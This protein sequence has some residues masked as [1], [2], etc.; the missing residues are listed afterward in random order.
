MQS[1]TAFNLQRWIDE[2]R[3]KLQPPVCNQQVF[4]EDDFIV[5]IVGGPNSRDD[6]HIDKGPEL[7]YQIEG[8]MM[9]RTIQNDSRVDIS[10]DEGEI[11]LLPPS[12]PHS[13]QRFVN[14]IGLVVER[15][16]LDTELDGFLWYC[17]NC[18]NKL[19]EEY[20]YIADIVNQL[21][22]I[23]EHFYDSREHR[24]CNRCGT[25]KPQP[26]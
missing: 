13:P 11:L 5:M 12:V 2:H 8:E 19:Y 17:D 14:T 22:P 10:I 15:K 7:F 24:T 26:D 16:R 21:P 25:V 18:D 1:L 6:Y 9:L 3:D 4:E 23:F 20:I